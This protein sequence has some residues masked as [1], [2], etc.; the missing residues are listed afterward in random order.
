MHHPFLC[1]YTH[2]NVEKCRFQMSV[3]GSLCPAPRR[4]DKVPTRLSCVQGPLCLQQPLP[5]GPAVRGGLAG[6]EPA[7]PA[8]GVLPGAS[9][10]ASSGSHLGL[11]LG[12][13]WSALGLAGHCRALLPL[14]PCVHA[15]PG[16][17]EGVT[18]TFVRTSWS[19]AKL[20]V[21][22]TVGE[23]PQHSLS[24][25]PLSRYAGPPFSPGQPGLC[26]LGQG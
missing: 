15:R 16:H 18:V 10:L 19:R 20:G 13:L 9:A 7:G 2:S 26:P 5:E 11:A 25:F 12:C 24:P 23:R 4:T 17:P 8:A 1:I 6:P 22:A 21:W 3:S 14:W